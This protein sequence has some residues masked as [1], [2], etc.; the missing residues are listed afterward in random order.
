MSAGKNRR[1]EPQQ[2]HFCHG[3]NHTDFQP[4]IVEPGVWRDPDAS[5]IVRGVGEGY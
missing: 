4:P 2:A 1:K 3:F 5:T